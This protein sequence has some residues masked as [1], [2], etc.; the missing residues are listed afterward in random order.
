MVQA[1]KRELGCSCVNPDL[2]FGSKHTQHRDDR[3][4]RFP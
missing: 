2:P 1:L 3:R 4:I